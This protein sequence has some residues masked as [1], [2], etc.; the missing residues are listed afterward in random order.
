MSRSRKVS[1]GLV[2]AVVLLSFIPS[3]SAQGLRRDGPPRRPG[4][5]AQRMPPPTDRA[6]QERRRRE[7]ERRR[8]EGGRPL[9][10]PRQQL[11]PFDRGGV[12]VAPQLWERIKDLPPEERERVIVN[13]ERFRRMPP[14]RQAVILERFR[15]FNALPPERQ[16]MLLNR[17]RAWQG[18]TPEQRRKVRE[19]IFP[20]WR[21]LDPERRRLLAGKL[22]ELRDISPDERALR[23]HDPEFTQGLSDPERSL[24]IDLSHL[25]G[26]RAAPPADPS[27]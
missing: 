19:E 24:L 12:G 10:R 15:R 18:L 8:Q 23:L 5:G 25:G 27:P 20:R 2:L 4:M 16:Q 9:P 21:A 7:I 13:D 22:R 26:P 3:V 1:I 17:Q 6:E 14:E 11:G